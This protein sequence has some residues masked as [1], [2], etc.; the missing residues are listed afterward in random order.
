MQAICSPQVGFGVRNVRIS[1]RLAL[2]QFQPVA[3]AQCLVIFVSRGLPFKSFI[4]GIFG[5]LF[6]Q[7]NYPRYFSC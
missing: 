7:K 3:G 2:L 5:A 4:I 1:S 6:L